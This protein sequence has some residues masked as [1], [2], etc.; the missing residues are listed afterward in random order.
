[1][2]NRLVEGIA[3]KKK[4]KK[5]LKATLSEISPEAIS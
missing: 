1:M 2:Y 3:Q 4:K 5:K